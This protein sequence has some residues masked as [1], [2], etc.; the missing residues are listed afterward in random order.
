M[1][2]PYHRRWWRNEA[3]CSTLGIRTM[4][5][6]RFDDCVNDFARKIAILCGVASKLRRVLFSKK[7]HKYG[8]PMP[9]SRSMTD[10]ATNERCDQGIVRESVYNVVCL[11]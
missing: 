2:E 1:S 5:C 6:F 10:D 7:S 9:P 3:D 8:R 4:K 11:V